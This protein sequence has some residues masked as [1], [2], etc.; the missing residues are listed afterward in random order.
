MSP[1]GFWR[2]FRWDFEGQ[3]MNVEVRVHPRARQKRCVRDGQVLRVKLTSAPAD[4]K[5]NE[6][7]AEILAEVFSVRKSE[8]LIVRG[9][10]ARIKLISL[11]LDE[12]SFFRVFC[13]IPEE[14]GTVTMG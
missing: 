9:K 7:L 1:Y 2:E 14:N 12:R 8:V 11:P 5:A 6:E 4:G 13:G 3:M 10:K